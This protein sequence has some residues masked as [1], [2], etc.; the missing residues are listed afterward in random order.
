VGARRQRLH[1][2][3]SDSSDSL[4]PLS[5]STL[6]PMS[7]AILIIAGI[8]FLLLMLGIA[9]AAIIAVMVGRNASK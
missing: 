7:Y 3:T 2:P 4:S 1:A 5:R 6:L 9:V 8:G